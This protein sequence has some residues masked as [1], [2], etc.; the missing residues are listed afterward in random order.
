MKLRL[1]VQKH[2][3]LDKKGKKTN[4][5]QINKDTLHMQKNNSCVVIQN[6]LKDPFLKLRVI[7]TIALGASINVTQVVL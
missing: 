4:S 2:S 1:F 3:S 7:A 6:F 5:L